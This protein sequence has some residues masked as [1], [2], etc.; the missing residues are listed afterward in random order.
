MGVRVDVAVAV[1]VLV[2]VEVGV[3]VEVAVGALVEVEVGVPVGSIG[4][5][6]L[7]GIGVKTGV[8]AGGAPAPPDLRTI[9][10]KMLR[11]EMLL[12]AVQV[13]D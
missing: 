6:E 2:G 11:R 9:G 1:L 10:K 4:V 3:F 13:P 7:V 8:S 5:A 12:L